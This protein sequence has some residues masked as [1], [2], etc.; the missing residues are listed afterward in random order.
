MQSVFGRQFGIGRADRVDRDRKAKSRRL[1]PSVAG[2]ERRNLLSG[3]S[4]TMQGAAAI[5]TL[6]P[7]GPNTVVVS[8]QTVSGAKMLDVNLNG[9]DHDFS[10]SQVQMVYCNGSGLSGNLTFTNKNT[11]VLTVAIG[12]SGNNT[13]TG[14]A[15]T[16]EFVGGSGATSTNTFNAGTGFDIMAG[17]SGINVYYENP[18]GSGLIIETGSSNTINGNYSAYYDY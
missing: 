5:V 2:L 7:S 6:A 12:G 9:T 16:D 11:S 10:P 14:G 17:G 3:G 1:Q 13:F 4:V 8:Y 15:G 18:N